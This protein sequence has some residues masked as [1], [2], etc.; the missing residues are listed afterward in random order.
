MKCLF[1]SRLAALFLGSRCFQAWR[2]GGNVLEKVSEMEGSGCLFGKFAFSCPLSRIS[3][4]MP[5][6]TG[7]PGE[8]GEAVRQETNSPGHWNSP[9]LLFEE[10][11]AQAFHCFPQNINQHG[12]LTAS[13]S[14]ASMQCQN[15][16]VL[17]QH[18]W[19]CLG[20]SH[21]PRPSLTKTCPQP[22]TGHAQMACLP[23]PTPAHPS[24]FIR[25]GSEFHP[26][27]CLA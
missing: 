14:V 11:K 3:M 4:G 23:T 15:H 24:K 18:V 26:T 5:V 13:Q 7:A 25:R 16:W 27:G 2:N 8:A 20:R 19:S 10:K 22:C 21:L 9:L 1:V 12:A 6:T 17:K